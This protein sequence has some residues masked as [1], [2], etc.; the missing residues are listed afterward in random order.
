MCQADSRLM[1]VKLDVRDG[2]VLVATEKRDWC[3]KLVFAKPGEV[4]LAPAGMHVPDIADCFLR[5]DSLMCGMCDEMVAYDQLTVS[6]QQRA[7]RRLY[8]LLTDLKHRTLCGRGRIVCR[9]CGCSDFTSAKT[10]LSNM[11]QKGVVDVH[12]CFNVRIV[13]AGHCVADSTR[14]FV[15]GQGNQKMVEGLVFAESAEHL[16]GY[17]EECTHPMELQDPITTVMDTDSSGCDDGAH[18]SC[19]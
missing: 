18:D 11:C 3:A 15:L 19:P 4:V 5:L 2:V 7:H 9:R 12:V 17:F 14:S 16:R 6:G 8:R 1:E 10:Y 13:D